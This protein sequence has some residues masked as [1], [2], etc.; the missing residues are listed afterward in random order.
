VGGCVVF[1]GG[2]VCVG[3]E[4]GEGGGGGGGGIVAEINPWKFVAKNRE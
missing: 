1:C 3:K 4:E 2:V